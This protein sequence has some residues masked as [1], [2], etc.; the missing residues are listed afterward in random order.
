MASSAASAPKISKVTHFSRF[1]PPPLDPAFTWTHP[2]FAG[3]LGDPP[4]EPFGR[5]SRISE[6]GTRAFITKRRIICHSMATACL[7]GTGRSLCGGALPAHRW[8]ISASA[9]GADG[10]A[11]RQAFQR[12]AEGCSRSQLQTL[13]RAPQCSTAGCRD[14]RRP[15]QAVTGGKWRRLRWKSHRRKGGTCAPALMPYR[16]CRKASVERRV[17][18]VH[19]WTFACV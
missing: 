14:Q 4:C 7:D 2:P 5:I 15:S 16:A 11:R 8:R 1:P 17:A 3:L 6:L 9:I 18:V 10:L 12:V 19:S 13:S